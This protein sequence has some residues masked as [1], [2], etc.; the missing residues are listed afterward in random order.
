M[1]P[2]SPKELVEKLINGQSSREL[3]EANDLQQHYMDKAY[4]R[5]QTGGSD[6][7]LSQRDWHSKSSPG[8]QFA[9]VMGNLNYQIENGGILQWMDNGYYGRHYG[10]LTDYIGKYGSRYK[11]FV[12]LGRLL[13]T[14]RSTMEDHG[15]DPDADDPFHQRHRDWEDA[16]SNNDYDK[17]EELLGGTE[18]ILGGRPN[19]RGF[20]E[21]P[22]EEEEEEEESE[23]PAPNLES[24]RGSRFDREAEGT[25]PPDAWWEEVNRANEQLERFLHDQIHRLDQQYDAI[26]QQLLADVEAIL[27]E[28]FATTMDKLSV[29]TQALFSKV[30][31]KVNSFVKDKPV[32]KK[33]LD[34]VKTGVNKVASK[35]GPAINKAGAMAAQAGK[36][37]KSIPQ[38][39]MVAPKNPFKK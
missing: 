5:I 14:L 15:M 26:S 31:D 27:S 32:L 6:E 39:N 9:V 35:V 11:S 28:E 22:E 25:Y 2:L 24:R 19:L 33:G 13:E 7:K 20:E 21:E 8:E 16:C 23:S 17:M 34:A 4:S 12:S 38:R 30:S 1:K 36:D 10:E 18:H 37:L 29:K 3:L